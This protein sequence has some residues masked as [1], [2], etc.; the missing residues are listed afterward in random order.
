MYEA[1]SDA[2]DPTVLDCYNK[3]AT[4]NLAKQVSTSWG[5]PENQSTSATLTAENRIF[6]QMAAQG[7][8]VFAASGDNGA[9]DDGSTLSVDDPSSQPYVTG[10]GGTALTADSGGAYVSETAWGDRTDTSFS[11]L[12]SGSG[13]G[14]SKFWPLPGYQTGLS[15]TPSGRSVPDV[16]LDSDPGTGY[17]IYYARAWHVYG[18]TSTAVPIWAGFTARVNQTRAAQGLAPQ[19]FLNPLIY[20]IGASAV[21]GSNFHDVTSGNNLFYSAKTG[22]DNATG[23]GSFI[24]SALLTTLI[25]GLPTNQTGTVTGKATAA[26]AGGPLAGVTVTAASTVGGVMEATATTDTG[27]AYTLSVPSQLSLTVTVSAYSATG[28]RYAGA[29]TI[30]TAVT[31]GQALP[32]SFALKPAH[33]FPAGIQMISSPYRY[34]SVGDF[35]VLFG[36]T[37]PL[38]SPSPHLVRWDPT[39]GSYLFYPA[40]QAF[41]LTPGQGYWVNFP[42]ASYIHFDGV[43]VSTSQSYPI[44]LEAGWNQIGDPFPAAAPLSAIIARWAGADGQPA[45]VGDPLRLLLRRLRRAQP[46]RELAPTVHRLL[47]LRP[48]AGHPA[49][50]PAHSP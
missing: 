46:K 26:D 12:G 38:Q 31:T 49:H 10:V 16:A 8:S 11:A 24:G 37:P 43:P 40:A 19:G 20:Q 6:Q 22:Y 29:K 21:Y 48:P 17:S 9:Y 44:N 47:D 28:G 32:L 50:S 2:S 5:A 30:V 23:W 25:N 1:P 14:F 15:P 18:G 33:T 35:A 41:T 45:R 4:D 34:D 36:L 39:L 3:I 27:G 13:G 7:Q 42:S